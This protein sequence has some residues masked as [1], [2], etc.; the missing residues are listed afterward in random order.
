MK[1]RILLCNEFCLFS[2]GYS[3]YGKEL[4]R[5]L[6]DSGKYEIAEFAS[7]IKPSDKRINMVPWKVYGNEPENQEQTNQYNNTQ[8]AEFGAWKFEEVSLDFRPD[9][10]LSIRDEWMDSYIANSPFR[11]CYSWIHMATVDA[12][13]QLEQWIDTYSK[14]D[15]VLNYT[16]WGQNVLKNH[17]LQN[18]RGI[19]SPSASE[20]FRPIKNAKEKFG[21][22]SDIKIIGTVMRNQRR[23]L[24]PNLFN[25]FRQY[26]NQTGDKNTYLYCHTSYPDAGWDIPYWIK[27]FNISTRVL[28]TYICTKC[29]YVYPSMFCDA[30][31][32]CPKCA[33]KTIMPNVKAGV[34]DDILSL[35]YNCFDIYIQYAN[36]EGFGMP[37]A[38]AAAC[39]TP[40][41]AVDYSAMSDVVKKVNGIPLKVLTYN[42]EPESGCKR[43][44]PDDDYA[45]KAII[46]FFKLD[47]VSIQ[48]ISNV[49]LNGFKNNY[50][51]DTTANKWM[52]IIDSLPNG[53][54]NNKS[55]ANNPNKEFKGNT[56]SEFVA[57]LICDVFGEPDLQYSYLSQRLLR[58]LNL[59]FTNIG[60]AG[61]YFN[62]NSIQ[63]G[64]PKFDE[65][66]REHA[67]K[68]IIGMLN[69]KNYWES[70]RCSQK[71]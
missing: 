11:H 22:M 39:G 69:K 8:L 47:N 65:F 51:W 43:A 33:G 46:E 54:W 13:P 71:N 44:V 36:S 58:D 25:V 17:G 2:T 38:E 45:V 37:I 50:S 10:V 61:Y 52:S 4:L 63:L 5:R 23:K 30:H 68:H 53:S 62:E 59:G 27:Y 7:Y 14:A 24:Y 9:V 26:L 57:W 48:D 66:T 70:K 40:I 41:M 12:E 35:I 6:Y 34:D 18:L 3:T 49:T 67:Y 29:Y 28:F 19:T 15:A 20:S 64:K 32:K 1:K 16:Q 42:Y 56:N 60:P 31:G 55:R 21:L